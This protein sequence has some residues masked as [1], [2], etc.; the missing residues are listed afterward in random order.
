V[1]PQRHFVVMYLAS[2]AKYH[3]AL[4]VPRLINNGVGNEVVGA[5]PGQNILK[6]FTLLHQVFAPSSPV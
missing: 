5:P 1:L 6:P 4:L 2:G 3:E